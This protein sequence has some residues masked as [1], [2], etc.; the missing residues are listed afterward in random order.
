MQCLR[1]LGCLNHAN[2]E[3]TSQKIHNPPDPNTCKE[4]VNAVKISLIFVDLSLTYLNDNRK[5]LRCCTNPRVSA[6]YDGAKIS[7]NSHDNFFMKS[8]SAKIS[9]ENVGEND[10]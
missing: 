8:Q 6:L 1:S 7:L 10:Y 4:K 2:F 9:R 5:K 3:P